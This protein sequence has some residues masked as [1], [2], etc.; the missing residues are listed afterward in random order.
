MRA[1]AATTAGGLTRRS[2]LRISWALFGLGTLVALLLAQNAKAS[3]EPSQTATPKLCEMVAAFDEALQLRFY[4]A[5]FAPNE[6]GCHYFSD[7]GCSYSVAGDFRI[8]VTH[9]A[10]LGCSGDECSFLARQVCETDR[11]S[12]A[13]GAI[14]PSPESQYQVRGKFSALQSGG[15]RLTDW[16]REHGPALELERSRVDQVCPELAILQSDEA[17]TR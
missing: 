15:W 16:V 14:M 5:N 9:V 13:C 6:F 7:K 1:K 12:A 2:I 10:P 8:R 4:R 17:T 3:D 11:P